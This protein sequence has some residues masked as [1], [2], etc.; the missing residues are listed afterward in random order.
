[1]LIKTNHYLDVI[2][3]IVDINHLVLFHYLKSLYLKIEML[4]ILGQGVIYDLV[5]LEC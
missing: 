4:E 3:M 2:F 1:M 5:N